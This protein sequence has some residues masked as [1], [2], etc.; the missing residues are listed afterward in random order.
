ME[1]NSAQNKLLKFFK[2]LDAMRYSALGLLMFAA[3]FWGLWRGASSERTRLAKRFASFDRFGDSDPRHVSASFA[4]TIEEREA[5]AQI[6]FNSSI[7]WQLAK[8]PRQDVENYRTWNADKPFQRT[9]S[10]SFSCPVRS[11]IFLGN[12]SDCVFFL[13][14]FPDPIPVFEFARPNAV[15]IYPENGTFTEKTSYRDIIALTTMIQVTFPNRVDS[16]KWDRKD[17]CIVHAWRQGKQ[18]PILMVV[19]FEVRDPA[20]TRIPSL[21]FK[22]ENQFLE[23]VGAKDLR[24]PISSLNGSVCLLPVNFEREY[25]HRGLSKAWNGFSGDIR[26]VFCPIE[27]FNRPVVH[28]YVLQLDQTNSFWV[29]AYEVQTK[30]RAVQEDL[31]WNLFESR[32]RLVGDG[33]SPWPISIPADESTR[34]GKLL[35]SFRTLIK[36]TEALN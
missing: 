15:E 27:K 9:E 34:R 1:Q 33:E 36:Q 5:M 26:M 17:A 4:K 10:K 28:S 25:D 30:L 32:V 23:T 18:G 22:N 8:P 21:P 3:I 24:Y 20:S 35:E 31:V 6:G 11:A 12:Y 14:N 2:S 16:D 19:G 7:T 29:P 13:V